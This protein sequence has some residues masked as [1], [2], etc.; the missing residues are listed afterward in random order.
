MNNLTLCASDKKRRCI[1]PSIYKQTTHA[2]YLSAKNNKRI[3]AKQRISLKRNMKYVSKSEIPFCHIVLLLLA[4]SVS[5]QKEDSHLRHKKTA[6]GP[7][8]YIFVLLHIFTL[9]QFFLFLSKFHI[10]NRSEKSWGDKK[11]QSN[12]RRCTP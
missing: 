11:K 5:T 6:Y 1:H 3:C 9:R 12:T 8:K 7:K 2:L 10:F 4:A